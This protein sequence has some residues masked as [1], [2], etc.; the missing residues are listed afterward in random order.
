MDRTVEIA[1]ALVAGLVFVTAAFHLWWG[2]PRTIV[3]LQGLGAITS[4]GIVP[5]PRPF[6]F[7]GFGVALLLG[8]YLVTRDTISLR[9]TYLAGASLMLLSFAFWVFWHG[10]GHGAFLT[11]TTAPTSEGHTHGGV[12]YTIYD[13]YVTTPTEGI[14]KS[15]ELLAAGL[16]GFLLR[17]DPAVSDAP[18]TESTTVD[19]ER[20]TGE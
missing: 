14:I 1:R 9:R 11:G 8:P 18:R 15:V 12:L 10:T 16:F 19:S 7:V 20:P 6:L 17:R 4:Q 13:H 2:F 3:Y 5:D